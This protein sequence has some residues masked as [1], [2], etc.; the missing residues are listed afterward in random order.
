MAPDERQLPVVS[1]V[2]YRAESEDATDEVFVSLRDGLSWD[3]H[4]E[5]RDQ[6]VLVDSE[7][8]VELLLDGDNR[9]VGVLFNDASV[10]HPTL[11]A[12]A[13]PPPEGP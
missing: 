11:L 9:V 3:P 7:L 6:R 5:G 12:V 10:L 4:S 1:V 13:L 8:D 2:L